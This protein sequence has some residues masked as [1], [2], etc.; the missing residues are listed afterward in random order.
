LLG[1]CPAATQIR[2]AIEVA[3]DGTGQ[4]QSRLADTLLYAQASLDYLMQWPVG[5]ARQR[6]RR[7][8]RFRRGLVAEPGCGAP[9]MVEFEVERSVHAAADILRV[10]AGQRLAKGDIAVDR[11]RMEGPIGS[12]V[13]AQRRFRRHGRATPRAGVGIVCGRYAF[14]NGGAQDEGGGPNAD[15][16]I[17]VSLR[18]RR[19]PLYGPGAFS[20]GVER[21]PL[22]TV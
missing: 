5:R 19:E 16:G 8:R 20:A 6:H 10:L 12:C 2:I 13:E 18:S 17:G 22:L 7:G 15:R 9:I 3:L 11:C 14:L 21:L 4:A 1:Q